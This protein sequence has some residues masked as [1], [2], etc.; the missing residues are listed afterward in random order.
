MEGQYTVLLVEDNE[1]LSAINRRALAL[2]GYGV[3]AATSLAQAR[4]A[5]AAAQPDIILLDVLLPDGNGIDFCAEI[6][7]ATDAHILFLTSCAAHEDRVRGLYGGG[8]DYITKPYKLEELLARVSAAL[9]RRGMARPQPQPALALGPLTLDPVAQQ[10]SVA[11]QD[12]LLSPKEFA[13]LLLL[14]QHQGETLSA[15][16]LYQ[17]VWKAPMGEDAGALWRQIS[18]LKKKLAAAE[19]QVWITAVRGEGYMLEKSE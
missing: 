17:A 10:A 1:A 4:E 15:Q 5:L 19:D 2:A 16:A 13:L 8:D 6:R 7:D 3:Q 11:G 14:A 9:R 12:L 18:S